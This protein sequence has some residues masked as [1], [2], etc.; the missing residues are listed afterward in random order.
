MLD[1]EL[2]LINYFDFASE[3]ENS[4]P[5]ALEKP[6]QDFQHLKRNNVKPSAFEE[7]LIPE[8]FDFE[9]LISNQMLKINDTLSRQYDAFLDRLD[10]AK[11]QPMP[12]KLSALITQQDLNEIF[13]FF[14]EVRSPHIVDSVNKLEPGKSLYLDKADTGLARTL[15]I[16]RHQRG[17]YKLIVETKSKLA[18]GTKSAPIKKVGGDK[19][20]KPSWR[21]DVGP[22]PYFN[23]VKKIKKEN[24][25]DDAKKEIRLSQLFACDTVNENELGAVYYGKNRRKVSFYSLKADYDLRDLIYESKLSL[26]TKQINQIISDILNAVRVFHDQGF[27]FQDLKPMNVLIYSDGQG[28]FKAKL[29]DFGLCAKHL[30]R[31]KHPVATRGFESP[32]IAHYHL[33]N[34]TVQHD[35]FN[36][37]NSYGKAISKSSIYNNIES[38]QF[39]CPHKANDMWS[40]GI[41]FYELKFK[42]HPALSSSSSISKIK[43]D[44]LICALLTPLRASRADINRAIDIHHQHC[45]SLNL[46]TITNKKRQRRS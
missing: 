12:S 40:L 33:H 41:L 19:T 9:T 23:L 4:N 29:T 45:T 34:K 7:P 27:V 31:K 11:K 1:L 22:T 17:E 26:S 46:R 30:A 42:Q 6:S 13:N 15:S 2:N 20:G 32:E 3:K 28:G 8:P 14:L 35:Y 36:R 21:V 43:R 37:C 16:L 25:L 5:N 44:P 39:E 18:N 38:T 24:N 10:A